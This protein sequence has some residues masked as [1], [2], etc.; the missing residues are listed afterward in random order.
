MRFKIDEN[1]HADA[2]ELLRQH[3]HDTMTVH[4]Q[5]LQGG[6]DADIA[7][8]CRQEGRAVITLDLDFSDVRHYPPADYQGLIVL[9][10]NDQSRASVLNIIGRISPLLGVEP[11]VGNLW[12]VQETGVRIR[13][14]MP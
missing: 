11:L 6:A 9:R 3:G 13:E 10:L 14:G 5:G 4:E 8:V 12:I 7:N 2:A 1:L